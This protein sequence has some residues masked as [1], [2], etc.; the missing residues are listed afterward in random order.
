LPA[1]DPR[2]RLFGSGL[3]WVRAPDQVHRTL[4]STKTTELSLLIAPFD[5]RQHL[6]DVR[7]RKLVP[8]RPTDGLKLA[9]DVTGR[10][11]TPRP[12]R[13]PDPLRDRQ[14]GRA[15]RLPYGPILSVL[16]EDL[17]SMTH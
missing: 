15:S 8:R 3:A 11:S 2:E 12:Q 1:C 13:R 17:Q 6:V 7:S 9:V 5:F 10:L 16:K 14:P 4:E